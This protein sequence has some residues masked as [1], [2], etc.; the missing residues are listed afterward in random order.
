LAVGLYLM[1][2]L[3]GVTAEIIHIACKYNSVPAG[4]NQYCHTRVIMPLDWF[5][6]G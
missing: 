4:V 6:L 1:A 2:L 5:V 3:K